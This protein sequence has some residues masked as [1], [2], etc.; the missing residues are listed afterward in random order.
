MRAY[1]ILIAAALPL[2][3]LAHVHSA[4][5]APATWVFSE[6]SCL[7]APSSFAHAVQSVCLP[8]SDSLQ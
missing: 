1:Q 5:A 4:A 3:S 8:H 6:T 2:A 7:P